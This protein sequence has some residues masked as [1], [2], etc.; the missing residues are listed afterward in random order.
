MHHEGRR[1]G[2]DKEVAHEV[3][4]PGQEVYLEEGQQRQEGDIDTRG[5]AAVQQGGEQPGHGRVKES[6]RRPACLSS[7]GS[8]TVW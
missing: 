8:N 4:H 5:G 7:K 3:G 2:V 1:H 6:W